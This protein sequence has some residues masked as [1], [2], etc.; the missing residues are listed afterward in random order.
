[1]VK[2]IRIYVEGGGD[3]K[4]RRAKLRE[5][6]G[7]FL[8]ELRQECQRRRIGWKLILCGADQGACEQFRD[9]LDQHSEALCLLLVDADQPVQ[10]TARAHIE[11]LHRRAFDAAGDRQ[12][13][14]MAQVMESW[15]L[16]DPDA[17]AAHFGRDFHRN[18]LP[19]HA[20]VEAVPKEQVLGALERAAKDT[21]KGG[22]DKI[23]DGAAL[24][25]K[26]SPEKTRKQARHCDQLFKDIRQHIEDIAAQRR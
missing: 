10:G 7:I 22:Y 2:E 21:K 14:L 18:A 24:L 19:K 3:Q 5:G 25:Q 1:M 20:D 12:F 8:K 23:Q 4:D 11:T 15:F 6:F 17:L 26:I 9:A 13:H 16:A